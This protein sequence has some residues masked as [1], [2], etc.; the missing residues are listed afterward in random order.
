MRIPIPDQIGPE[1]IKQP[2]QPSNDMQLGLDIAGA[3]TVVTNAIGE[4]KANERLAN[5][6]NDMNALDELLTQSDRIDINDPRV[7]ETIRSGVLENLDPND[8]DIAQV[9]G[10]TFV[11]TQRIMRD[12][13]EFYRQKSVADAE[14]VNGNF[15]QQYVAK[16]NEGFDKLGHKVNTLEAGYIANDIQK[17]QLAAAQKYTQ[18]GDY[19]GA[20]SSITMARNMGVLDDNGASAAIQATRKSFADRLKYLNGEMS[21]KLGLSAAQG[22]RPAMDDFS[23]QM[24][25][26]LDDAVAKGII[27]P[28]E[29][30]AYASQNKL[31]GEFQF[32]RGQLLRTYGAGGIDAAN[33]QLLDFSMQVPEGVDPDKWDQKISSMRADLNQTKQLTEGATAESKK[34][35]EQRQ[36]VATGQTYVGTNSI[37]VTKDQKENLD[38]FY[39]ENMQ[40]Y[41]LN[42]AESRKQWAYETLDIIRSTK[43]IPQGASDSIV[44]LAM[45]AQSSA[46]TDDPAAQGIAEDLGRMVLAINAMP[47][48][49]S[50]SDAVELMKNPYLN[51]VA[52][53]VK[54][55]VPTEKINTTAS[56]YVNVSYDEKKKREENIQVSKGKKEDFRKQSIKSMGP[57]I[58]GFIDNKDN[59]VN[60]NT[61]AKIED[62]YD[63]LYDFFYVTTGN[64]D[65][66][67]KSAGNIISKQWTVAEHGGQKMLEKNSMMANAPEINGSK[68]WARDQSIEAINMVAPDLTSVYGEN[69]VSLFSDAETEQGKG[70]VLKY[71]AGEGK[72]WIKYTTPDSAF[73]RINLDPTQ[74]SEWIQQHEDAKKITEQKTQSTLYKQE[75]YKALSEVWK[76][77]LEAYTVNTGD[78]YTAQSLYAA[79]I[80]EMILDATAEQ[81]KAAGTGNNT[82]RGAKGDSDKVKA[83]KEA[84]EQAQKDAMK[85]I[86]QK[87]DEQLKASKNPKPAQSGRG[88]KSDNSNS[89]DIPL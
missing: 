62:Q 66:A 47:T 48:M 21:N 79:K 17:T 68:Q 73:V 81:L 83:I 67:S 76:A 57:E 34:I 51:A 88:V 64:S 36:K 40:K 50:N 3:A 80:S 29:R 37:V 70:Y 22:N 44:S 74:S 38:A 4:A 26:Q 41:D 12:T 60:Q 72:P 77:P 23:A 32:A 43:N 52:Y 65:L 87:T 69:N 78:P 31:D 35:L 9:D 8:P 30:N 33:K 53:L 7:P 89:G 15:R 20:V 2:D 84:S 11:P 59:A 1:Y 28:E 42:D 85:Y 71:R 54:S 61:V 45:A 55:G 13:V 82:G 49:G 6:S 5:H 46:G 18:A 25:S 39:N 24:N 10:K 56:G 75:S 58:S 86:Y 16:I 19:D 63:K 27:T 14:N